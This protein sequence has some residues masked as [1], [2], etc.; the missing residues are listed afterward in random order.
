MRKVWRDSYNKCTPIWNQHT[1]RLSAPLAPRAQARKRSNRNWRKNMR[2]RPS[3]TASRR[4]S[5]A[6]D[7]R[8]KTGAGGHR[9]ARLFR[10]RGRVLQRFYSAVRRREPARV[11][12]AH[13]PDALRHAV[14]RRLLPDRRMHCATP[15]SANH[16]TAL[17]VAGALEGGLSAG[18]LGHDVIFVQA[19][20]PPTMGTTS[21][22]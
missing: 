6:V 20:P 10:A 5:A 1:V 19:L 11:Q 22:R 12:T 13:R 15:P 4:V 9:S 14:V 3:T 8:R 17:T 21:A 7:Q 18:Q 16:P 2:R